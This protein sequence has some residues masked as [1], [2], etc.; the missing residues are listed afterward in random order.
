MMNTRV[1]L[2]LALL[3]LL[4]LPV[5]CASSSADWQPYVPKAQ[6]GKPLDKNSQVAIAEDLGSAIA[7][8][9]S[10]GESRKRVGKEGDLKVY[11]QLE[12]PQKLVDKAALRKTL[13]NWW[14]GPVPSYTSLVDDMASADLFVYAVFDHEETASGGIV[15]VSRLYAV[16]KK[17]LVD[18]TAVDHPFVE[19]SAPVGAIESDYEAI[20][21]ELSEYSVVIAAAGRERGEGTR[22]C[23]ANRPWW[24]GPSRAGTLQAHAGN[25]GGAFNT[26]VATGALE[27]GLIEAAKQFTEASGETMATCQSNIYVYQ[28]RPADFTP[29]QSFLTAQEIS[30]DGKTWFRF[31]GSKASGRFIAVST[32]PDDAAPQMT[33]EAFK[34]LGEAGHLA[35]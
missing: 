5:G 12:D 11:L 19:M 10:F 3:A 32:D 30:A 14:K 8:S 23:L 13:A 28:I 17:G 1:A 25:L 29:S 22:I 6:L 4:L 18:S 20:L 9:T 31:E 16:D 34:A 33:P 35:Y 27:P 2:T 15:I 7:A 26:I 21:D 24:V